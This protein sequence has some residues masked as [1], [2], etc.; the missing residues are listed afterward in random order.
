[1]YA[2]EPGTVVSRTHV[3]SGTEREYSPTTVV[4]VAVATVVLFANTAPLN[5]GSSSWTDAPPTGRP[6]YV[7]LPQRTELY[8]ASV[9]PETVN[10]ELVL[11]SSVEFSYAN[12]GFWLA[13]RM[14]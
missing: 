3:P 13:G 11:V 5:V 12:A 8:R 14:A 6:L 7:A 1:M 4:F 9:T 2:G 10:G